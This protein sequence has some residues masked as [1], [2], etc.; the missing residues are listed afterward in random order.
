MIVSNGKIN[1]PFANHIVRC[2]GRGVCLTQANSESF[3]ENTGKHKR[4]DEFG[5]YKW[6]LPGLTRAV[7]LCDN[8]FCSLCSP[9][10]KLHNYACCVA[11]CEVT[12]D[13]NLSA[14][15]YNI[16][17]FVPSQDGLSEAWVRCEDV[18]VFFSFVIWR[19]Y[20]EVQECEGSQ[21]VRFCE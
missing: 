17:L 21:A 3:R 19:S 11:G 13:V 16:K 2:L 5:Q 14:Q 6:N 9:R 4:R 8:D 18:S 1:C 15:K 20:C 7:P 12:P 10:C